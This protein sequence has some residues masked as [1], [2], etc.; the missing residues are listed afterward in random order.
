MNV[1]HESLNQSQVNTYIVQGRILVVKAP[2]ALEMLPA[3]VAQD[4]AAEMVTGQDAS[5]SLLGHDLL[6]VGEDRAEAGEVGGEQERGRPPT[7]LADLVLKKKSMNHIRL[8]I[9]HQ[10]KSLKYERIH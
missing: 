3:Q 2:P 8:N 5:P 9:S 7:S 1:S 6:E 4:S 10:I